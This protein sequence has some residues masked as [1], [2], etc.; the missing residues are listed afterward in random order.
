MSTVSTAPDS[1]SPGT[2]PS[3]N[4]GA[5]TGLAI[6]G[7]GA[8]AVVLILFAICV[9][10]DAAGRKVT[11]MFQRIAFTD[12]VGNISLL[13]EIV[14]FVAVLGII[15]YL[16]AKSFLYEANHP[17]EPQA[18]VHTEQPS[19]VVRLFGAPAA[20]GST[21]NAGSVSFE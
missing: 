21:E 3:P 19:T 1:G 20:G 12:G 14:A 17:T 7:A 8:F 6:Y 15:A 10:A 4:S 5:A 18:N 9:G 13:T 11:T 16:L 2:S